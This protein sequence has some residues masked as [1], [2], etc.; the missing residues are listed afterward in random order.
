MNPAV[1]LILCFLGGIILSGIENKFLLSGLLILALILLLFSPT[2]KQNYKLLLKANYF[3]VMVWLSLS[4]QFAPESYSHIIWSAT[5]QHLALII[6]LK[7]NII[8]ILAR[9]LLH[10]LNPL[11]LIIA[12]RQLKISPKLT[13]LLVLMLNYIEVFQ[14]VKRNQERAMKARGFHPKCNIRTFKMVSLQITLLLIN[15]L[16]KSESVN[17]ALK[18]RGFNISV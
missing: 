13:A 9:L 11:T 12:F 7:F 10:K 5:G 16:E 17:K 2:P 3:C 15:A 6:T 4:W 8:F 14:R 1:R 18:A